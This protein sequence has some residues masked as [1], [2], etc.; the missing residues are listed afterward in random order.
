VHAYI[1][2][3]EN[4]A[5]KKLAEKSFLSFVDESPEIFF[6][7]AGSEPSFCLGRRYR[8]GALLFPFHH[9]AILDTVGGLQFHSMLKVLLF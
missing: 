5:Y 7:D 4:T 1:N 8:V 6:V 9:D 3:H 2:A